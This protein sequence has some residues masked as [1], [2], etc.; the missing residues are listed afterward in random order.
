MRQQVVDT[1]NALRNLIADLRPPALDEL[2]LVAALGLHA[3][4]FSDMTVSVAIE[5]TEHRLDEAHELTLFR[6]AQ[7]AL[8]NARVHGKATEA[9]VVGVLPLP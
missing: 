4:K 2:G 6:C 7:E 9:D 1:I 5:G 3:E 8:N